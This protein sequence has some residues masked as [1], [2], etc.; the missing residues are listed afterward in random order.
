MV[1]MTRW[2][3]HRTGEEEVKFTKK[4]KKSK[5]RERERKLWSNFVMVHVHI[6]KVHV[7]SLIYDASVRGI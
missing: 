3:L 5:E 7:H 2:K 6:L 4:E 1:M